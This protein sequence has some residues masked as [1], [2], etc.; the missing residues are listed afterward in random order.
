MLQYQLLKSREGI[1]LLGDYD[2][3]RALHDTVHEINEKS[4]L[5]KD[6][7][8]PF[9]GLAYDVR[10]AY[11]RQRKTIKPPEFAPEVGP[12]YG[13]DILWPV[14]LWQSFVLRQSLAF[15][16]HGKAVQAI[17]YSLEAVVEGALD[18]AFKG[19]SEGIKQEVSNWTQ[20]VVEGRMLDPL[21]AIFTRWT[22]KERGTRMA[23]LIAAFSSVWPSR[24][25]FLSRR[26]LADGQ[27]SPIEIE[28]FRGVEW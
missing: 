21:G 18:D 28:S 13:V 24:Y 9:L 5:L 14:L 4:P 1:V 17:T 23:G 20:D 26:G 2:S 16:T 12:K 15:V 11:E 25:E 19:R 10:K 8:G 27:L 3:L 6:K 22:S 7:E